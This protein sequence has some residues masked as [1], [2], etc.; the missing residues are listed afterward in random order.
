MME[1]PE[2]FLPTAAIQGLSRFLPPRSNVDLNQDCK[3]S[4]LL[5]RG[6]SFCASV[7]VDRV[8]GGE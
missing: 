3:L 4:H 1:R 6:V 8:D 5:C 7:G 2:E